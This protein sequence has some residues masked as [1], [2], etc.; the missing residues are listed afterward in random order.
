M[1]LY[2]YDPVEMVAV[3]D[4]MTSL[5]WRRKYFSPGE[6]ELHLTATAER[7][8]ALSEGHIIRRTDRAE[9]AII[10]GVA[11]TGEDLV[12]TGRM[13]SSVLERAILTRTYD[14][15]GT[16]ESAM[17]AL[18]PEGQ[19]AVPALSAGMAQGYPAVLEG[20]QATWK[21]LLTVEE[22]LARASGLGFLVEF[23]PGGPWTFRCTCG[24]DHSVEQQ[25]N[26]H[27]IFSEEFGNLVDPNYIRDVSGYRNVAYV[28]GEG[29]GSARM[30]VTVDLSGGGERRELWVDAKDIRSEDLD[31]EAYQAALRQRGLEKLAQCVR[32]ESFEADGEDVPNFAYRKDWDLGDLVTAQYARLGI[33]F[34][35][36]ITEV[37]EVYENGVETVTPTLGDP[38]P[39]KLELGEDLT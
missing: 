31:P 5:R 29:E 27:V 6:M 10:E 18:I 16:Y 1:E 8:A 26:P 38:L 4:V 17:L 2:I 37:E 28:G 35:A 11:V 21:N 23:T 33:S 14:L 30:V 25:T 32:V 24:T 7:L 15:S 36:R 3:I 39:E 13:L 20:M 9:S 19:R 22:R 34:T 12:I